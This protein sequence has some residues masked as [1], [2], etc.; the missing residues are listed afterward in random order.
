MAMGNSLQKCCDILKLSQPFLKSRVMPILLFTVIDQYML[1]VALQ[2]RIWLITK[3]LFGFRVLQN[4]H[5]RCYNFFPYSPFPHCGRVRKGC[6]VL[7]HFCAGSSQQNL[8]PSGMRSNSQHP[9]ALSR[10]KTEVDIFSATAGLKYTV[11]MK[12]PFN[13]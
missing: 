1:C 6:A 9:V 11:E 7:R 4:L 2:V 10:Q 3:R 12:H 13:G 8:E 5:H